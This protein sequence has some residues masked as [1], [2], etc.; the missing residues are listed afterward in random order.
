[1][2][3]L[4]TTQMIPRA[5]A[6][7]TEGS[8]ATQAQPNGGEPANRGSDPMSPRADLDGGSR[9]R[10]DLP[11]IVLIDDDASLFR[12]VRELLA[13]VLGQGLAFEQ[14]QLAI[15][16]LYALASRRP[17]L[18]ILDLSLPD[19]DGLSVLK[20][21]KAD[22]ALRDIPVL[23]LTANSHWHTLSVALDAGADAYV[24]KPFDPP[25]LQ[26][27]ISEILRRR[28]PSPG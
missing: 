5:S 11:R 14:H 7:A 23:I 3:A 26:S 18:I 10:L 9:P 17:H 6:F 20:L 22:P 24:F 16:A 19:L 4:V 28:Y 15:P 2:L 13:D 12:P 25:G 8:E 1:M 21:L 27:A